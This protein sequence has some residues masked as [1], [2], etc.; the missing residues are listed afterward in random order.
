VWAFKRYI[1]ELRVLE[2]TAPAVYGSLTVFIELEYVHPF[3]FSREIYVDLMQAGTK[4]NARKVSQLEV[5]LI[6]QG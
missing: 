5:T 3:T 4:Y 1:R 6:V 2:M